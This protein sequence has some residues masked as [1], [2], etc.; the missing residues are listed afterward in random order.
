MAI[1]KQPSGNGAKMSQLRPYSNTR[2]FSVVPNLDP[3]DV[4]VAVLIPCYN[5]EATVA[6]V[7]GDF[8]AALPLA[9]VYVYDNAS[10]DMTPSVARAAGAVV[11]H[12]PQRGKGTRYRH[13]PSSRDWRSRVAL[14]RQ[15]H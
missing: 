4:R 8:R 7:V 11:V 13:V 3:E 15:L 6:K 12:E 2:N 5:E 1:T 10:N 9:T 14:D